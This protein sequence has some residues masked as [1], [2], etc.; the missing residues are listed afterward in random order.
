MSSMRLEL[1]LA[2]AGAADDGEVPDAKDRARNPR[3]HRAINSWRYLMVFL[4]FIPH[5]VLTA[6]E[7]RLSN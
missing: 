2:S 4:G 5:S 6:C 3:A 1:S 7:S